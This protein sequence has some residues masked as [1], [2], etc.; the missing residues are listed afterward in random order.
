M[1]I[2]IVAVGVCAIAAL[3]ACSSSSSTPG[4]GSTG[5]S[6]PVTGSSTSTGSQSGGGGAAFCQQLEATSKKLSGLSSNISNPAQLGN[7][8]GPIVTQLQQLQNGAPPQVAPALQDLVTAMQSASK[9]ASGGNIQQIEKQMQ[10]LAP[11]LTKDFQN[12]ETYV[13]NNCH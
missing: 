4:S 1:R 10:Q 2:R 13:A 12:L 6:T 11:K 9:A 8:L 7:K 5:T 3:A